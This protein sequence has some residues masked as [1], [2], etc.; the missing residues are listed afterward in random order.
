MNEL[1]FP[2]SLY[3]I[4]R[5]KEPRW[6]RGRILE[7][8]LDPPCFYPIFEVFAIDYGFTDK[9]V[10]IANIRLLYENLSDIPPLV[11]QHSLYDIEPFDGTWSEECA[12]HM[13]EIIQSYVQIHRIDIMFIQIFNFF[14]L[15]LQS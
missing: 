4:R 6:Y 11:N 2:G 13:E 1:Y 7:A 9:K 15:K 5:N 12:L 10:S 3:V 8:Q 14:N